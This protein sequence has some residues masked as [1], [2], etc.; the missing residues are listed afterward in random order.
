MGPELGTDS[1]PLHSPSFSLESRGSVLEMGGQLQSL[2][3]G[4][5]AQ[6][7]LPPISTGEK[8]ET[9]EL[10]EFAPLS[11]LGGRTGP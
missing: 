2:K 10:E 1:L 7:P 8:V 4:F 9:G 3:W 6:G 11:R 5:S